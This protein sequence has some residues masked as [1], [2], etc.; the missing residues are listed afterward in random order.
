[1]GFCRHASVPRDLGWRRCQRRIGV[2]DSATRNERPP[3]VHRGLS[4]HFYP[5]TLVGDAAGMNWCM[6]FCHLG[7]ASSAVRT[8][9][10]HASFQRDLGRRRCQHGIGVWGFAAWDERPPPRIG[11]CRHASVRCDLG[12]RHCQHGIG[13]WG[14]GARDER[15]PGRCDC[16]GCQRRPWRRRARARRPRPVFH[17]GERR[18]RGDRKYGAGP[19]RGRWGDR[20]VRSLARC[21]GFAVAEE[22]GATIAAHT[23]GGRD[24]VGSAVGDGRDGKRNMHRTLMGIGGGC[25]KV[26]GR[27]MAAMAGRACLRATPNLV[28]GGRA[29]VRPAPADRLAAF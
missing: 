24:K 12:S 25:D 27:R 8:F 16:A 21:P 3:R 13:G 22:G 26:R 4:P 1:M 7:C 15:A 10:S 9:C 5:A 19:G 29:G 6:G 20:P 2:W 11:F 14:S 18:A 17:R 28:A 23:P